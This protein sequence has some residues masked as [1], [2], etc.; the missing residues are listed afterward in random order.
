MALL[1]VA[2]AME[3]R[4]LQTLKHRVEPPGLAGHW[5]DAPVTPHSLPFQ[6]SAQSTACTAG[7]AGS[8]GAA[9]PAAL[10]C[11]SS[12]LPASMQQLRDPRL[13]AEAEA[14]QGA[15]ACF[16]RGS[17]PP[18]QDTH[19]TPPQT[20]PQHRQVWPE[21]P[22]GRGPPAALAGLRT[23]PLATAPSGASSYRAESRLD[24]SVHITPD[25]RQTWDWSHGPLDGFRALCQARMLQR[26]QQ[27]L[28]A[29][30][31]CSMP[32]TASPHPG[33][34][35]GVFDPQRNRQNYPTHLPLPE[36]SSTRQLSSQRQLS[37]PHH[38]AGRIALHHSPSSASRLN[39]SASRFS[40]PP[41]AYPSELWHE[42]LPPS[43]SSSSS[44]S[45]QQPYPLQRPSFPASPVLL[46]SSLPHPGLRAQ[47]YHTS[48]WLSPAR[49]PPPGSAAPSAPPSAL[50]SGPPA[51]QDVSLPSS[52]AFQ[53]GVQ[54]A[55]AL[56]HCQIPQNTPSVSRA[57]NTPPPWQSNTSFDFPVVHGLPKLGASVWRPD[58]V[59]PD[60]T[61]IWRPDPRL[62]VGDP[63]LMVGD[64]GQAGQKGH[65]G[66]QTDAD[67]ALQELQ[68]STL[69]FTLEWMASELVQAGSS[70][71]RFCF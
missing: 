40:S 24:D 68:D 49:Q 71:A 29:A 41:P 50:L 59:V 67:L 20:V 25:H 70:D 28:S 33:N 38:P 6:T 7:T 63:Q 22:S 8:A 27:L 48:S 65:V 53:Q 10:R 13:K 3:R 16:P 18:R 45:A 15:P 55:S 69:E 42:L 66:P 62:A 1:Q 56:L 60:N 30:R 51:C 61:C 44:S 52:S 26:Q 9:C 34:R 35:A 64:Y 31:R 36:R 32:R 37:L 57:P 4:R 58:A 11:T 43:S 23:V 19:H 47:G 2:E 46:P 5:L 14:Q 12:S 21:G 54:S 17:D 39:P